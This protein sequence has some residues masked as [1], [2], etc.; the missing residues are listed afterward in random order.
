MA[1]HKLCATDGTPQ[2]QTCSRAGQALPI[3]A[4]ASGVSASNHRPVIPALVCMHSTTRD[5]SE[6]P[7]AAHSAPRHMHSTSM[8]LPGT[9][10]NAQY[11]AH[12]TRLTCCTASAVQFLYIDA[13]CNWLPSALQ[14]CTTAASSTGL[15]C[16]AWGKRRHVCRPVLVMY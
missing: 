2:V 8:L 6:A 15:N 1:H 11:T 10:D 16:A 12:N 9:S 4:A 3:T 13:L 5:P 14:P 7:R